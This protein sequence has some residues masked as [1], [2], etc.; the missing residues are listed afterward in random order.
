MEQTDSV[1][2]GIRKAQF[3]HEQGEQSVRDKLSMEVPQAEQ[4]S[5]PQ[6]ETEP[7]ERTTEAEE[8]TTTPK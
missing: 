4:P 2:A 7:A 8:D 6:V 3:V 1:Q 5:E